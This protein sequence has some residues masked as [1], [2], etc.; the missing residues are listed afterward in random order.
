MFCLGIFQGHK[1]AN[2]KLLTDC[3][4]DCNNFIIENCDNYKYLNIVGEN[5]S[6]LFNDSTLSLIH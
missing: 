3:E 1:I 5:K 6:Y 2:Y 4:F